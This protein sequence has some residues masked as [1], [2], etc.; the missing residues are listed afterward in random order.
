MKTLKKSYTFLIL[1]LLSVSLFTE[2]CLKRKGPL[3][4]EKGIIIE[5]Q[6]SPDTQNTDPVVAV[7]S[8]G[9]LITGYHFS[10]QP[11]KYMVIFKC[12]HGVVFSINNSNVYGKVTVKD[13]VL[14]TY[15]DMVDENDVV[16]DFDFIDATPI[17]NNFKK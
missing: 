13:S 12:E 5:K 15:F 7:G 3:K 11:E 16:K 10:G 4:S 2:S 1:M 8:N 17:N 9:G 14:I 6:Y